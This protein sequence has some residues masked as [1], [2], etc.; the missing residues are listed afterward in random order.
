MKNLHTI[1][2]AATAAFAASAL[3]VY[4]Q[5]HGH[6]HAATAPAM[7]PVAGEA[8]EMSD[9]EVRKVD[10]AGKKITLRH[11]PLKNLDMPPMTM[12]FQVNDAALLDNVKAGDKVRFAASNPDGKLTVTQIEVAK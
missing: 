3:P 11:G 7:K 6:N 5:S 8:A 9:G 2:V 10:K 12:V 4:A 1:I